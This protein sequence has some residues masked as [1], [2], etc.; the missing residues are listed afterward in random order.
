MSPQQTV[1]NEKRRE[2]GIRRLGYD[3]ARWNWQTL[4]NPR[5]L[6]AILREKGVPRRRL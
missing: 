1:L 2:D 4:Q 5:Q 3:V 6:E